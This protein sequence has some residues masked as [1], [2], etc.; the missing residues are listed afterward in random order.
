MHSVSFEDSYTIADY[1]TPGHSLNNLQLAL[2]SNVTGVVVRYG[3]AVLLDLGMETLR[4]ISKRFSPFSAPVSLAR[5]VLDLSKIIF[6]SQYIPL[7]PLEIQLRIDTSS[8]RQVPNISTVIFDTYV[9]SSHEA[10]RMHVPRELYYNCWFS[11]NIEDQRDAEMLTEPTHACVADLIYDCC[12]DNIN[13]DYRGRQGVH[14]GRHSFCHYY[15]RTEEPSLQIDEVLFASQ[16][17]AGTVLFTKP[18]ELP[19]IARYL[20]LIQMDDGVVSAYASLYHENPKLKIQR[21]IYERIER[22]KANESVEPDKPIWDGDGACFFTELYHTLAEI[23][24]GDLKQYVRVPVNWHNSPKSQH[25]P[26]MEPDWKLLK[27]PAHLR[28]EEYKKRCECLESLIKICAATTVSD[29][30]FK[31]SGSFCGVLPDGTSGAV[32]GDDCATYCFR[33][34]GKWYGIAGPYIRMYT[35][36]CVPMNVELEN[37]LV[38]AVAHE[39]FCREQELRRQQSNQGG[40]G[41]SMAM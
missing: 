7:V 31:S 36:L 14:A 13:P 38:V 30:F 5:K 39:Q 28:T 12:E 22:I 25:Y 17:P 41:P 19:V 20:G 26:I 1:N 10:K 2:A 16:I 24:M 32:V 23:F 6:S 33:F 34:A 21:Q 35:D 40:S 27:T 15:S 18:T 29:G 8:P 3:G 4:I 9:L 11:T 37:A